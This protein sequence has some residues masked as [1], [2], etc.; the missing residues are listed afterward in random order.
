MISS[1]KPLDMEISQGDE[2]DYVW[3][4][5]SNINTEKISWSLSIN[6][7]PNSPNLLANVCH[8][9]DTNQLTL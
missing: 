7:H 1:T 2:F 8:L 6:I 4:P 9:T 5:P 3:Q